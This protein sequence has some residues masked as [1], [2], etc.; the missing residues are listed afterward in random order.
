MKPARV[1]FLVGALVAVVVA[2]LGGACA[3]VDE[4][5]IKAGGTGGATTAGS[6]GGEQGGSSGLAGGSGGSASQAGSAGQAGSGGT[7]PRAK[8]AWEPLAEI[9]GCKFERVTNLSELAPFL[10]WKPCEENACEVAWPHFED[11]AAGDVTIT[12]NSSLADRAGAI[13]LA[14]IIGSVTYVAF[15]DPSGQILAAVRP[16]IPD[17]FVGGTGVTNDEFGVQV[18]WKVSNLVYRD[19]IVRINRKTGA[20]TSAVEVQG[21]FEGALPT[22]LPEFSNNAWLTSLAYL[23]SI[24]SIDRDGVATEVVPPI[25]TQSLGRAEAIQLPDGR[26]LFSELIEEVPGD[27]S[28]QNW[29]L[30]TFAQGAIIDLTPKGQSWGSLAWAGDRLVAMR[31]YNLVRDYNVFER[32]EVWAGELPLAATSFSP[33]L[34]GPHSGEESLAQAETAAV[35]SEEYYV[36]ALPK[37]AA[38]TG[39]FAAWNLTTSAKREVELPGVEQLSRFLGI[40]DGRF[41]LPVNDGGSPNRIKRYSLKDL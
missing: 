30:K 31:A 37:S 25:G 35:A 17:C 13:G 2:Q 24:W 10:E 22:F 4:G 32:S 14:F 26:L 7:A 6:S 28:S 18:G 16:A 23:D 34:L 38:G 29:I 40:A 39:R 41:Y 9:G 3:P 27:E 19:G 5:T 1:A 33:V 20:L 15:V 21:L 8:L 36:A 12:P 11:F